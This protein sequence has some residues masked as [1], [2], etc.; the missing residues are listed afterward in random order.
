M[1]T[2]RKIKYV[3]E[4]TYVAEVE[5]DVIEDETSW[6]PYLSVADAMRLDK[7]RE[8]LRRGDLNAAAALGKVYRLQPL[9]VTP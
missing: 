4:G 8:A 2:R 9:R 7:A 1:S 3:H 5:V 6:S